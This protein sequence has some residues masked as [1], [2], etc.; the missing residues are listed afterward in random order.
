MIKALLLVFFGVMVQI[1]PV[2]VIHQAQ[3]N[4]CS[5]HSLHT[6][7]VH[8]DHHC[9]GKGRDTNSMYCHHHSG[10]LQAHQHDKE[11]QIEPESSSD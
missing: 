3:A 11:A 9:H 6:K 10:G 4:H 7:P 5:D 8:K 1:L 2:G